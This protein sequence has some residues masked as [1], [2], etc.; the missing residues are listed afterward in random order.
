MRSSKSSGDAKS[1]G[2][3]AAAEP[4]SSSSA[5]ASWHAKSV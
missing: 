2:A 3:H 5:N 1:A 4:Q